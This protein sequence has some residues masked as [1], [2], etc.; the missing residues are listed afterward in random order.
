MR[1]LRFLSVMN[2]SLTSLP[3]SLGFLESLRLLKLGSNPLND[4]LKALVDNHDSSISPTNSNISENE[5][6]AVITVKIKQHLRSEA[7]TLDSPAESSSESPLDTPKPLKR[8][9]TTL[10]FP[11]VPTSGGDSINDQ[12]SPNF[13]KP[14][15]PIRSHYRIPSGQNTV[16][17][18]P[19][20]HRANIEPLL[21]SNERNRSHSESV[22]QA[23][24]NSRSKRMGMMSKQSNNLQSLSESLVNRDSLHFRGTS[25]G[26]A[27]KDRANQ[28]FPSGIGSGSSQSNSPT[29]ERSLGVFVQRLSSVPE[30]RSKVLPSSPAVEGAKGLVF[31][32][33]SIHHILENLLSLTGDGL[34]KRSSLERVYFNAFS[35]INKLN[36]ELTIFDATHFHTKRRR[37]KAI[38]SI[39][40]NCKTC[41]I[42]YKQVITSLMQSGP[43]IIGKADQRY[44]RRL[45]F[46]L[47][48][49]SVEIANAAQSLYQPPGIVRAPAVQRSAGPIKTAPPKLMLLPSA[50][51]QMDAPKPTLHTSRQLHSEAL[52]SS[53]S[54][55]NQMKPSMLPRSAVVPLHM[56]PRSR[57]NS[58]TTG[59]GSSN[60][61]SLVNTPR[62]GESFYIPDTPASFGFNAGNGYVNGNGNGNVANHSQSNSRGQDIIFEQ[63][64][65]DFNNAVVRGTIALPPL[66]SQFTK[67]FEEA[68]RYGTK[69]QMDLWDG[70]QV[71][72]R[73]CSETCERLGACLQAVKFKDPEVRNS[74]DFWRQI[75]RYANAYSELV[76]T[77]KRGKISN[78]E[79]LSRV[80]AQRIL[81]PL[82]VCIKAGSANI[83]KSPWSWA[84]D[85]D[86]SPPPTAISTSS[87]HWPGLN[88]SIA[89][90]FHGAGG[91]L[92]VE[93][94]PHQRRQG[95]YLASPYIPTTPSSAALGP[96]AQA[97]VPSSAASVG[98]T[99]TLFDNFEGN[100]FQ[101]AA[102]LQELQPQLRDG[103]R[104]DTHRSTSV[105][106]V[107]S[108]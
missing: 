13:F 14:P 31:G 89:G 20:F 21:I 66:V 3:Y 42:A 5:K 18:K 12:R 86:Q 93:V 92:S 2:N 55:Q 61:S 60:L 54:W 62:S 107:G 79:Q 23:T 22:I 67:Q 4:S 26:S 27:A 39:R 28:A 38:N 100:V 77:L 16:F 70:L 87:S 88:R 41:I 59:P 17:P 73:Q 8:A 104:F 34:S 91:Q 56:G 49:S 78:R 76:D 96:A 74:R 52:N 33:H 98:P 15:I 6:E 29:E 71:R 64:Y 30:Q 35:H 95:D 102:R 45:H 58:R 72:A 63:I 94:I 81:K 65:M 44:V 40:V 90:G 9:S 85:E 43:L 11:V 53:R 99:I 101:R 37:K 106:G 68:K 19:G 57:S 48:Y 36:Q 7:T 1:S 46:F 25:H 51:V 69:A 103:R 75:T 47:Y 108:S 80:D 84:L 97:T 32:L 50:T 24:R 105:G 82:H 83:S 10:R